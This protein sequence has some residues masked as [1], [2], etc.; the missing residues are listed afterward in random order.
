MRF[1]LQIDKQK[2]EEV[3][4]TVHQPSELT[5]QIEELVRSYD[6]QDRIVAYTEDEMRI[7]PFS[8]IEC[9]TILGGQTQ[10]ICQNGKHYR[11]KYRLSETVPEE[12]KWSR[13]HPVGSSESYR[14]LHPLPTYRCIR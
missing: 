14:P 11:L 1:K 3:V 2:E 12:W 4:A 10:A 9:I 6:G 5:R 7:L 8:D 13:W